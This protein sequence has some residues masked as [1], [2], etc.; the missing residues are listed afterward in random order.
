[1]TGGTTATAMGA[2][3]IDMLTGGGVADVLLLGD[4]RKVFY[5]HLNSDNLCTSG[6]ARVKDYKSGEDKLQLR[7]PGHLQTV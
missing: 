3:Q 7:S 1:M 6:Y 2:N 5:D 4:S